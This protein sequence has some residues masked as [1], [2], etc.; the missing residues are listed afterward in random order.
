MPMSLGTRL[1]LR[2][3]SAVF[4]L[5]WS[6]EGLSR[7]RTFHNR[8]FDL[9]LYARQAW[10]LAHGD[11]YDPL[12]DVHFLGTHVALVLW[13][14]GM[15]G[16]YVGTVP[17]LIIAQAL[18]L[19]FSALPIARIGARRFGDRGAWL[20]AATWLLYPNIGHVASYEFHPGSI[21]IFALA[22]ALDAL[23]S[24]RA[25]AFG[26]ACL[27]L[28]LCRADFA[29]VGMLLGAAALAW[30][31]PRSLVW[32]QTS[33]IVCVGSAAYLA[34]QFLVLKRLFPAGSSSLDLHFPKWGGSPFGILP[35]LIHDPGVVRDHFLQTAK[36]FYIPKLLLPVALLPLLAPRWLLFALPFVAINSISSFP[37]TSEFYSHYL[38][39][40]LPAIV[41]AAIDGLAKLTRYVPKPRVPEVAMAVLLA[42][43][44]FASWH[45]G[46]LPW[47]RDFDA[48]AFVSDQFTGEARRTAA[49]IPSLGS[50]QAPDALLPHVAERS[51]LYRSTPPDVGARVVVLD[52]THRKRYERREDLLRTLEEPATRTWLSRRDYGLIHV[53]NSL[54]T[55]QRGTDP[56]TGIAQRYLARDQGQQSGIPLTRCLTLLSAWLE[57]QGL[58]LE[59]S[60]QAPCPNDLALRIGAETRPSRV[61]LLFD[62]LLSPAQLRDEYAV[63]WHSL[64]PLERE[65]I[66][67]RGLRIGALRSSGDP[68]EL[69][70]PVTFLVPL[71]H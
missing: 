62:G 33:A 28:V 67:Q 53:E 65:R 58:E 69:G 63:S 9:A 50:V 15:L 42:C 59:F 35:A 4:A 38:T 57:P 20:A 51:E 17:V 47:S 48:A 26:L 66:L 43:L 60:T 37:T 10:G 5:L 16:S 24:D 49:S 30:T 45:N 36:L 41:V 70:D 68:P 64:S 31:R 55:L 32:K 7:Y 27:G 46:G 21:G 40:A 12:V 54:L 11:F 29:M 8:T 56:R 3:S 34:V 61:D 44:G 39:P 22:V 1:A 23:D 25:L 2:V 13:P 6:V 14:L 71:I 18:A 52:I 19:A